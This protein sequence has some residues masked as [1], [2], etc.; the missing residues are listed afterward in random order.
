MNIF[1]LPSIK[2]TIPF[3]NFEFFSF[4]KILLF[5][6]DSDLSDEFEI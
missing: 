4:E 6:N 1:T 2:T 5:R 3:A